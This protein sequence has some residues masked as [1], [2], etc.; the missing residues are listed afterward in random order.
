MQKRPCWFAI[1]FMTGLLILS[2]CNLPTGTSTA[3]PVNV[4]VIAS[5]T[6]QAVT[7]QL[8]QLPATFQPSNGFTSTPLTTQ[9]TAT[10]TPGT[11]TS[12]LAIP[13]S[14]AGC[15]NSIF[16]SDV[17]IPDGTQMSPGET[18]TKIWS[19]SNSGVCAWT[20][21][22]KLAF[23]G[24]DEMGGQDEILDSQVAVNQSI[25]LSVD[26]TAPDTPGEYTGAWF[27]EDAQGASFGEE[28]TVVIDV[29]PPRPTPTWTS[30]GTIT[31]TY[32]PTYTPT[33]TDT[34]TPKPTRTS[35]DTYTPRPTKTPK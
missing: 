34:N 20:S 2:A 32:T 7:A 31:Y 5:V 9:A 29:L 14:W 23:A 18:F 19:V 4:D 28:F 24:G 35:T 33:P 8:T 16:N 17:T 30:T 12:T 1:F 22:F 13:T 11:P 27:L 6:A 3:T 10:S 15:S 25:D 21:G 26:L